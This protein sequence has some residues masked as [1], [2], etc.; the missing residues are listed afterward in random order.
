ML[1]LIL[2]LQNELTNSSNMFVVRNDERYRRESECV[3]VKEKDRQEF[4]QNGLG[5]HG[6]GG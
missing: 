1:V 6:F 3:F 2:G 4:N 5:P